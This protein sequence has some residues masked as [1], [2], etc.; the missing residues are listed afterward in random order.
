MDPH[1]P[2]GAPP[3]PHPVELVLVDF[4]D[5][6]VDTAP[7]FQ[8]ARRRFY[9]LLTDA[10]LPA[11]HARAIHDEHVDPNLVARYG[12]GPHR[13]EPAFRETY[14]RLCDELGSNL[15][16]SLLGELVALARSV[17]G[18]PPCIDGAIDAL[19]TLAEAHPTLLFTQ[20]GIPDYQ[21]E[22]VRGA[23]VLDVLA[24][25]RIL[26]CQRK[27][28]DEFR[29]VIREHDVSH[30]LHAWMIGN[31]IRS[32]INPALEAGAN[33]I[34]VDVEDPWP[35]D[36]VE[37]VA[38]GFLRVRRF[39]EAVSVLVPGAPQSISVLPGQHR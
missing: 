8:N 33:A 13:L 10:G 27:T 24:E 12:L 2:D 25:E 38:N 7:R 32:D 19:R 20:S 16:H 17:A 14:V 4:D 26:I 15:D 9:A 29:R 39:P 37:P 3:Q 11:D 36:N 30:P 34:L 22:C 21:L 6:L 5:T 31:S 28:A 1:M 18:T 35:H 23:G